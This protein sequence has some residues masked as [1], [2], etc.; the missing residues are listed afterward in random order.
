MITLVLPTYNERENLGLI[1]KKIIDTKVNMKILIIDD[2]SPDGT[3]A[4]A[5][6]LSKKYRSVSVIHR[7]NERGLGSAIK[8]GFSMQS[9]ILGVMDADMSHDPSIIP[10]IIKEFEKGADF[11]IGSR[12]TEGGGIAD[13][14]IYRKI[15]S[16]IATLIVKPLTPVKDPVSGYF[17]VRKSVVKGVEINPKSCKVC[18]DLLVRGNYKKVVEV[19]YVFTNRSKGRTKILN[20]KEIYMYAK[21]VAYL[22]SYK[23][24]ECLK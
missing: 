3:G 20:A 23:I 11:V 2:N 10:D 16:K 1:V 5:D 12:Y 7:Y 15:I 18:L 14:T 22:Y 24:T 17:F 13:W 4:I 21:Y 6:T 9:D 19:P 8:R